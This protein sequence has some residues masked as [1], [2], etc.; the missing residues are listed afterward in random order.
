[1]WGDRGGFKSV[2]IH[3]VSR[4]FGTQGSDAHPKQE[5]QKGAHVKSEALPAGEHHLTIRYN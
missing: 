2:A 5:I 4:W 1:M 3:P